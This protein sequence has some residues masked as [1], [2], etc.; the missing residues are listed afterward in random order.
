MLS[1]KQIKELTSDF[2]NLELW[3][4]TLPPEDFE[5]KGFDNKVLNIV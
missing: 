2:Y 5:L 1:E 4:K 3:F